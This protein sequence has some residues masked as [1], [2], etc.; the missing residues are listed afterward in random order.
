M[1]SMQLKILLPFRVFAQ[2]QEVKR[3]VAETP[4]GSYGILPRRL[5][6]VGAL[7]PGILTYETAEGEEVFV[8]TDRGILVKAGSEVLV[9]VRNAI[10]GKE[11]GELYQA[12][13]GQFSQ[14][15]EH[16]QEVRSV[17][18]KLETG[19]IRQFQELHRE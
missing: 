11:L 4:R 17:M 6:G 12:V 1:E 19:F 18:V 14:L 3:I 16:E 7:A 8:A 15:D 10:G 2:V 9:S 5:D 13:E